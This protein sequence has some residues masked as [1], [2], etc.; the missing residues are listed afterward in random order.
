MIFIQKIRIGDF[1]GRN[2]LIMVVIFLKAVFCKVGWVFGIY[3]KQ[4]IKVFLQLDHQ[5]GIQIW[6][7]Q[8]QAVKCS[9]IHGKISIQ[10]IQ[11]KILKISRINILFQVE[12][13]V[14][15]QKKLIIGTLTNKYGLDL[16]RLL[17]HYG[18]TQKIEVLHNH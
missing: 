9:W 2:L 15:G 8:E 3:K 4:L 5:A 13:V 12:L 6:V 7:N 10:L 14:C 1:T 17:N 16:Q 11:L 18:V